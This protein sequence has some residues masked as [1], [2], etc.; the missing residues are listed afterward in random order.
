MSERSPSALV[1]L[2]R[3]LNSEE[4]AW[5]LPLP[6]WY[7]ARER[8]L[9]RLRRIAR[10]RLRTQQVEQQGWL[11]TLTQTLAWPAVSLVKCVLAVRGTTAPLATRARQFAGYLRLLWLHNL[12]I[13]DQQDHW[14]TRPEWRH[15]PAGY[16][17][18]RE[19]QALIDLAEPKD[20]RPGYPALFTKLDFD[21]F[22]TRAGLPF[23]A[24]L[25]SGTG[26]EHAFER[27]LPPADLV[28][29]PSD[30]G[31]GRGVEILSYDAE[32]RHWIG[33]DRAVVDADSLAAYATR[34]LGRL[35]WVVQRRLLNAPEWRVFTPGALATARIITARSALATRPRILGGYL[36]MPRAG[37]A[38][39][40]LCLGGVGALVDF[41]TGV[42]GP[43]HTYDAFLSAFDRHPDT[44]ATITGSVIPRLPEL[45]DLALRAHEAAGAWSSIGWDVALTTDGPCLIE[46]NLHWAIIPGRPITETCYLEIMGGALGR[47]GL[48]PGN[49][50]ATGAAA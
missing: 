22:C 24:T 16:L 5:M 34:R 33:A 21:A 35:R 9:R 28:L 44:G 13:A 29:K 50:A 38:G 18:C 40:N 17:A 11:P 45:V 26:L 41:E 19:H 42:L 3:W 49:P 2:K 6:P 20:E 37:E 25:A 12:R 30:G 46:A 32:R 15:H 14:L 43:G 1:H 27:P 47:A 8:Q 7:P 39:D 48:L 4:L 31:G 23:P 10:R 36:R